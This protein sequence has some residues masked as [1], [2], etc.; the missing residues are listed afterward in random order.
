M[1][2][3]AI[4]GPEDSARMDVADYKTEKS[5]TGE[6]GASK[7]EK[8]P[9]YPRRKKELGRKVSFT[10]REATCRGKTP[11]R[12]EGPHVLQWT[13]QENPKATFGT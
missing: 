2:S 10:E 11:M 5:Q 12:Q 13:S 1:P 6:N 8:E 7:D 3:V 4:H 9:R